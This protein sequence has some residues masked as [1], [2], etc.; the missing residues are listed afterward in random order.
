[1]QGVFLSVQK[2]LANLKNWR[3]I[4]G[5]Q[6]IIMDRNNK[7]GGR[8]KALIEDLNSARIEVR[9]LKKEKEMIVELAKSFDLSITDYILKSCL[10]KKLVVNKIQMFDE[11][12]KLNNELGMSGNNINQLAKHANRINKVGEIDQSVINTMIV[13][14]EKYLEQSGEIKRV[15]NNIYKEIA[16]E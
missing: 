12:L 4:F 16:N 1:M 3:M 2:P 10:N 6:N 9:C 5:T 14:L 13:L 8:P 11:F 7:K 15:V